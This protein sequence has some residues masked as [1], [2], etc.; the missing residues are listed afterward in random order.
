MADFDVEKGNK[1]GIYAFVLGVVYLVFGVLEVFGGV[2]LIPGDF[3][4]GLALVVIAATYLNG[5]KGVFNGEHKGLSFILGGLFLTTVFGVLYLLVMG[6]DGLMYLL[7]E[8]EEFSALADFR[9]A[10]WF[11]FASLPL[12]YGVWKLIREAKVSW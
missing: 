3:F 7:G 1:I 6:A 4:G 5:V 12:A 10:I 8:A 2:G 11:F 9:P